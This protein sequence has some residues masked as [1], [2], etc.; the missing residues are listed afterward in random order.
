MSAMARVLIADDDVR[1]REATRAILEEEGHFVVEAK[2]GAEAL[3]LQRTEQIDLV[4]C[5]MFM[6]GQDGI[7]TIRALR[8]DFPL[9]KIIAV[10]GGGYSGAI[11]V[12][13]MARLIGA[14]EVLSKPYSR[15]AL[16]EAIARVMGAVP[17]SL[18]RV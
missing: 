11:D 12:L 10:S 16:L 8:R 15:A 9:L 18:P 2:E 14:T 5:D 4:V 3:R 6:P 13:K 17:Q 1:L 7:E